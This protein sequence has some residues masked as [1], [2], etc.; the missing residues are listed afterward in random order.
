MVRHLE[1]LEHPR[2]GYDLP[3]AWARVPKT[4]SQELAYLLNYYGLDRA[5]NTPDYILAKYLY[6]CLENYLDL[7]EE[8]QRN[9]K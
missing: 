6:R 1:N 2:Y 3:D 7:E 4:F 8:K 9:G 5:A